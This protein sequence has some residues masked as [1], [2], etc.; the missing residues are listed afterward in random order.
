MVRRLRAQGK[1]VFFI[2]HFLEEVR[3]VCDRVLILR[4]GELVADTQIAEID[5]DQIVRSMVGREV[6]DFFPRSPRAIGEELLAG[7]ELF[8]KS[9]KPNGVTIKLRRGEILGIA[10]LNGAGRSELLRVLM[11]LDAIVSGRVRIKSHQGGSIASHWRTGMGIVSE[12]R[13]MEGLALSLSIHENLNLPQRRGL[14]HS[15]KNSIRTAEIWIGKFGVKCRNPQ[16]VIGL[17]SGGNQQK[18]AISRLLAANCDVLLLDEPTKGIDIGSK[19]EI[20]RLI[21][22]AALDGK[23][24]LV[25]SS[26][27]P[28]LMGICDRVA[29][30]SRGVLS[31]F[32]PVETVTPSELMEICVR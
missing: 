23:A 8:G 18:V 12:D 27:L 28:E 19:S 2:S 6:T 10:G 17:L 13:K 25:V 9:Q 32:F 14:W 7:F 11:G 29:V 26:Y 4:D 20:Y 5:D 3:A 21:D 22:E 1:T 31:D 15:P 24:I 30:M 16:Q